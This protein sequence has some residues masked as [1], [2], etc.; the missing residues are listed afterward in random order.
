M[1]DA[2]K[3]EMCYKQDVRVSLQECSK[4]L[5]MLIWQSIL[6]NIICKDRK[7]CSGELLS[8]HF[9]LGILLCPFLPS[10]LHAGNPVAL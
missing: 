6:P 2:L 10:W 3:K 5:N 1:R 8:H 7:F 9:T 4:L